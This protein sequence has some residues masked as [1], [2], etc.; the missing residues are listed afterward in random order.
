[1]SDWMPKNLKFWRFQIFQTDHIIIAIPL[2]NFPFNH[3]NADIDFINLN[4]IRIGYH[5]HIFAHGGTSS[6]KEA[7]YNKAPW[8]LAIV[9]LNI[10]MD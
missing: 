8:I 7:L 4:P 5:G 10:L 6:L 1:M 3:R 9:G 2:V